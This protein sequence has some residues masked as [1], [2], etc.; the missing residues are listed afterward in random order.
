MRLVA[1]DKSTLKFKQT[2]ILK[3]IEDFQRMDV[4]CCELEGAKEHYCSAMS[5]AGTINR[6]LKRYRIGGIRASVQGDK[7]F[8]Y[9]VEV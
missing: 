7:V 5:G 9:K 2:K 8:L 3:L 1:V 4:E 6:A